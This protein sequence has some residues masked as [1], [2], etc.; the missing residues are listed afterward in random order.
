MSNASAGATILVVEDVDTMRALLVHQVGGLQG[1]GRVVQARNT[2][3]ARR[4]LRRNRP[5]AV[6][7]DEVLPGESSLDLLRELLGEGIPVILLT[8]LEGGGPERA[9][10]EGVLHRVPKGGE[11]AVQDLLE[12]AILPILKT[13]P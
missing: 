12:N 1:V 8:S 2:W 9:L 7:L 13:I 5:H 6:L 3:E 11:G 4:E 10:P